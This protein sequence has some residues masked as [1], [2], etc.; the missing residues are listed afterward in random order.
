MNVSVI[1]DT[2]EIPMFPEDLS[3]FGP[4]YLRHWAKETLDIGGEVRVSKNSDGEITG[5]FVFDDYES[6]G[7]VFTRSREVFDYI[8]RTKSGS[9][10]W[11]ELQIG[12]AGE[13][14]DILTM[15]LEGIKFEHRFK[16]RVVLETDI[17]ELERFMSSAHEGLNPRW[18]RA[19]LASGDR[20]F[21]AKIGSEIAGVAWLSL[22]DGVGRVSDLYV[23]P[24]FRRSGIA[25]D[26]F[27]A[28]LIY[29]QSQNARSYFAEI[30]REN[31]PALK[32]ALN[33][34]MQ[35]SGRMYEYF[36]E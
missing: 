30:A 27:Y 31:E 19:S 16:H 35:V 6:D 8:Y 26:L 12:H 4:A 14:Y 15:Q 22:V 24:Q 1:K 21:A 25:R 23:R 3:Q 32:H 18:V 10:L 20:C 17:S 36:R 33:V 5:L 28:R 2:S 34:G 11:S 9:S 13:A 29:L 7:T